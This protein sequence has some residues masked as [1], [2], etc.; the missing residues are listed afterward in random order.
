MLVQIAPDPDGIGAKLEISELKFPIWESFSNFFKIFLSFSD[1]IEDLTNTLNEIIGNAS[2][3]M[4]S[5]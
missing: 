4:A 3:Y 1:N 2:N 5:K